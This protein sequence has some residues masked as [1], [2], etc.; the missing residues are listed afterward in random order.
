[1]KS[2]SKLLW[3]LTLFALALPEQ[4]A[5]RVTLTIT[6]TNQP[7]G[8][9]TITING[10]AARTWTNA[11][12]NGSIQ[13]LL[14]T[15]GTAIASATNL[16][17][18]IASYPYANTSLLPQTVTNVV[19]LLG[20]VDQVMSAS[21]AGAWAT[22]SLST[23]TVVTLTTVR[24]PITGE[25][26]VTQ[27][28]AIATALVDGMFNNVLSSSAV[29]YDSPVLANFVNIVNA[30]TIAGAKTFSGALNATNGGVLNNQ[31]ATNMAI[32]SG[33][34]TGNA[35]LVTNGLFVGS[36]LSNA[37]A[38]GSA[39]NS[40]QNDTRNTAIGNGAIEGIGFSA[41]TSVGRNSWTSNNNATAVG[42]A[43]RATGSSS[44]AFGAGA[45]ASGARSM[46]IGENVSEATDDEIKIGLSSQTVSVPGA[47]TTPT[48][49]VTSSA[50][51]SGLTSTNMVNRGNPF[52]SFAS[53]PTTVQIGTN[54]QAIS[55]SDIAIGALSKAQF[56]DALAIGYDAQAL[57]IATVTV[58]GGGAIVT[59]GGSTALGWGSLI[60]Q[61]YGVALGATASVGGPNSVALGYG[62]TENF[63][64]SVAIGSGV[65][66][67]ANNQ[68]LLGTTAHTV[69]AP[70]GLQT[71][72]LTGMGV[73]DLTLSHL[74][75]TNS[76]GYTADPT[77]GTAL[78]SVN[79]ETYYRNSRAS[80]GSG[81]TNRLFL[82]TEQATSAG[83]AYSLS[84][85]M[86]NISFGTTQALL[87]LPTAGTYLII[88]NI[89]FTPGALATDVYN[90]QLYDWTGGTVLTPG[91]IT[92]GGVTALV[93]TTREITAITTITSP[94]HI[95][96]I[97]GQNAT[98][99]RGTVIA[100]TGISYVRLY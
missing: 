62:A 95:V 19:R 57:S 100:P 20:N 39:F 26:S 89:L 86:T 24:V 76:V 54:A 32:A 91:Y 94:N 23:Q 72:S 14:G 77:N 81:Q 99:A 56:Q 28:E 60:S 16:W 96:F 42:A 10:A 5:Q 2:L 1:M 65:V 21:S 44:S 30:Q 45:S 71:P 8:L 25:P 68:I 63:S 49:T 55:V 13:I 36:T 61:P 29:V 78:W 85:T 6:L 64:N 97:Q 79:G 90:F 93:T 7:A 46:A 33:S 22:L 82:R 83:T 52:Q 53:D 31:A 38:K 69:V 27:Q 87:L 58:G 18:Q 12:G 9:N 41:E 43:A 47:I 74:T 88:G 11:V 84:T 92:E 34:F 80:E 73:F 50:I 59:G 4:A 3:L 75:L 98:A 51:L 40:W 15:N 70:G 67:T 66:G 48:L 35:G 37:V 17:N